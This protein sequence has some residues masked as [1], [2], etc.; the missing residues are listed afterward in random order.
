[1]RIGAFQCDLAGA[2]LERRLESLAEAAMAVDLALLV[3]PELFLCGYAPPAQGARYAEKADGAGAQRIAEIARRSRT[4]ILYGY[5]EEA[6]G[7]LYNAAQC[8]DADGRRLANHRKLALPPGFERAEFT[9]GAGLCVFELAGVRFGVLIC[10]D[11]EFPEAARACAAAGAEV[12]LAPTAL[13]RAWGVV[14][15]RVAPA[16]AFENGVYLLYA[17]HAGAEGA[18]AYWGGSCIVGPDGADLARAGA[19]ATLLCATLDPARGVS[20]RKRLPYLHDRADLTRR[21]DGAE[22]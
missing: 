20:A 13:G 3:C 6:D 7:V 12:L 18:I 15:E 17:N 8:I 21:L 16:R 9:P 19:D 2:S 4:A 1:M 10:Y 14:A 11:V 22:E 5:A